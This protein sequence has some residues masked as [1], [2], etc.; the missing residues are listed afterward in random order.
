MMRY[1][2]LVPW[3]KVTINRQEF[4]MFLSNIVVSLISLQS[5]SVDAILM[6]GQEVS[7]GYSLDYVSSKRASVVFASSLLVYFLNPRA[8][9]TLSPTS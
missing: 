6:K 2:G 7:S 8:E 1:N 4:A 5:I 3:D 9:Y